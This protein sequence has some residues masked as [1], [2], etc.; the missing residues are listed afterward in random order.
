[1]TVFLSDINSVSVLMKILLRFGEKSG[2]KVNLDKSELFWLGPW[3][4][5]REVREGFIGNMP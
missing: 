2:L 1:M 3:K 4:T 5:K